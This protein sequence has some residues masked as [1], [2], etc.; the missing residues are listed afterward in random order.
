MHLHVCVRADLYVGVWRTQLLGCLLKGREP[1][2][3]DLGRP[4]LGLHTL[5]AERNQGSLGKGLLLGP[6]HGQHGMSLEHLVIPGSKEVLNKKVA[7]QG[8]SSQPDGAPTG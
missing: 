6:G 7:C 4:D 3:W 1:C 5:P 2:A 8:L